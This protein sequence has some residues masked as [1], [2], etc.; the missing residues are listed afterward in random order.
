MQT[1]DKRVKDAE[2]AIRRSQD[3]QDQRR[4]REEQDRMSNLISPI[5]GA[6]WDGQV[7]NTDNNPFTPW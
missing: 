7:I 3:E 5:Q 6:L 1:I 4:R 2:D